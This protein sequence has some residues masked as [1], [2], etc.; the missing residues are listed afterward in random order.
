MTILFVLGIGVVA[1]VLPEFVDELGLSNSQAALLLSS[2][3]FGRM[4][5]TIPAGSITDRYGFRRITTV[6]AAFVFLAMAVASMSSSYGVLLAAQTVAGMASAQYT[7]AAMTTLVDRAG[8]HAIGRLLGAF[9]GLIVLV[10]SFAPAVG[11]F[12]AALFGIHGPFIVSAGGGLGALV[13]AICALERSTAEQPPEP[14][15]TSLP[16]ASLRQQ[17]RRALYRLLRGRAFVLALFAGLASTWSVAAIRN[18]LVPLFAHEELGMSETSIGLLLTFGGLAGLVGLLPSGHALDAVGRRPIVRWG[19]VGVGI[20]ATA[21]VLVD[22]I[23]TIFVVLGAMG[24][25]RGVVSPAPAVVVADIAA[26]RTRGSALA[27]SRMGPALGLAAGPFAAGLLSDVLSI[28][29][30]F[31]VCGLF[32]SL[33]ALATMAMPETLRQ[34]EDAASRGRAGTI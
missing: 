26:A 11:G 12:S 5:F 15:E 2:F 10:I 27:V 13:L 28:R 4:I 14:A 24:L 29:G 30:A 23:W 17:D 3:A 1:P 9:Q 19:M 20:T 8:G 25:A 33:L 7:T 31:L 32:L 21:F 18:T 34:P 16:S 6:S 22:S